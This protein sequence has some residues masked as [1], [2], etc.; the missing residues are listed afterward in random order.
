MSHLEALRDVLKALGRSPTPP[1]QRAACAAAAAA[2]ATDLPV[3]GDVADAA[4]AGP[5]PAQTPVPAVA[6]HVEHIAAEMR[7]LDDECGAA[8]GLQA[9]LAQARLEAQA[10]EADA[11]AR[12]DAGEWR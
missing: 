11:L 3:P 5:A 7:R 6:A 1:E 9:L 4:A 8:E 2:A 12:A 10:A